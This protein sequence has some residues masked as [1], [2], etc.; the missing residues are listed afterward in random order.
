[1]RWRLCV[2]LAG[3][4]VMAL[5]PSGRTFATGLGDVEFS[6]SGALPTFPCPQGCNAS[7]GGTGTGSGQAEASIGGAQYVATFTILAGSVSGS[8]S[9]TEPGF[10]F[11]PLVGSATNPTT[12]TVT[13][14]GGSTGIVYRTTSPTL[15]G[16]VT[17]VSVTL[18]YTYERLGAVATLD[19][20]GGSMTVSYFFPGSGASSFTQ[21]IVAGAGAGAFSVDPVQASA[22]CT[23]P[24]QLNFTLDGDV[25]VATT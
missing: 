7:F 11:C 1:M 20:T 4:V 17:G 10:P 18:G 24:G 25:A 2:A 15:T 12:G 19:I 21:A 13:L 14:S 23:N 22:L 5:M 8:A 16:T 6:V 3:S 9:Y